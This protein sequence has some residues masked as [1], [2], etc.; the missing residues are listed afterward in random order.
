MLHWLKT[1]GY[2]ERIASETEIV[3]V[4]EFNG[5]RLAMPGGKGYNHK[6]ISKEAF[7]NHLLTFPYAGVLFNTLTVIIGSM[8]GLTFKKNLIHILDLTG[9][10][11]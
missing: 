5:F 10:Y 6:K 2:G 1:A 4:L 8:T 3:N 9:S 7:M 11:H